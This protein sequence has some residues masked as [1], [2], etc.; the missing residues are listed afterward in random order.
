VAVRWPSRKACPDTSRGRAGARLHAQAVQRTAPVF[1]RFAERLEGE[2]VPAA[3][4][5][6]AALLEGTDLAGVVSR[7]LADP[8]D[9]T[10]IRRPAPPPAAAT[11]SS[12]VETDRGNRS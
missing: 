2:D 6:L 8:A 5:A 9:T 10:T 3:C 4:A 11:S 12:T 7:R 1:A